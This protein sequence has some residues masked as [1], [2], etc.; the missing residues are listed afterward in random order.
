MDDKGDVPCQAEMIE[1]IFQIVHMAFQGIGKGRLRRPVREAASHMVGNNETI[2]R[3]QG[4]YEAPVI[5]R[6]CGIAVNANKGFAGPFIQV[7]EVHAV[8]PDPPA[9]EGVEAPEG[10]HVKRRPDEG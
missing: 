6:P 9:P 4:R 3:G 10:I 1:E 2:M 8:P 7:M 5:E